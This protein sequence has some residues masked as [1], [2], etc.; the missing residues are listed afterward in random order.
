MPSAMG[1]KL[2]WIGLGVMGRSMAGH[3]L[4]A[5]NELTV[6]T[7]TRSSAAALIARGAR[8]AE[9]PRACAEG[10]DVVFSMVGL[11]ADVAEIHLGGSGTLS[12]R[13]PASLIVDMTTSSPTLARELA[14]QGKSRGVAFMDAP[15]SGGDVGAR[16]ARLSIMVGGET[17]AV[18]QVQPLLSLMG[19][20]I[21]HHG[22]AGCGQHAKVC[23]QILVAANMIG[24]SEAYAYAEAAGLEGAKVQQSV[25]GGAA[26]S[27]TVNNLLPRVLRGDFEPGFAV[28]HF[29][30]DL[31][32]ALSEAK[33][34]GLRLEGI[35]LAERAYRLLSESGSSRKGTQVLA[36]LLRHE[37]GWPDHLVTVMSSR[38][39]PSPS[40]TA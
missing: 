26:G 13:T 4:A 21:V 16:E 30:K 39:Q 12:A 5:G 9:S 35:A 11:P 27:W 25:A 29:L 23:N 1:R 34:M 36:E 7:R 37:R 28:A 32:I 14:S 40:A 20:T 18:E 22:A 24:M 15:V 33:S 17:A 3:L 8:W 31:D 38:D 6:F 10:Q 19:Q 2:G